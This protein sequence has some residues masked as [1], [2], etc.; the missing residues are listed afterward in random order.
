MPLMP[1][2]AALALT[3]C[4]SPT[5]YVFIDGGAHKGETVAHF[6]ETRAY[7]RHDWQIY[8]FEANPA[9]IPLIPPR[10]NLT[11][12]NQAIWIH[13]GTVE[14]YLG[15]DTV[16]SSLIK[17]KKTGGLSSEP[18]VVPCVDFGRWLESRFK[19]EDHVVV[20][21]DIEGAEYEVLDSML[22]NGTVVL[23]DKL[24]LEFHNTKV[25]VDPSRDQELR[26]RLAALRIPVF[27]Q[28]QGRGQ[29]DWFRDYAS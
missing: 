28:K 15:R 8:A 9:L 14:L 23:I 6:V 25:G 20:K 12:L 7:A 29:G 19:R 10:D 21:L 16:S 27:E 18:T 5:R 1:L 26:R 24:Y 13:D 17:D 2:L 11:V 3:A 4:A 22:E